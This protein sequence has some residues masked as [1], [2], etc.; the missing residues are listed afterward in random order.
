MVKNKK[1]LLANILVLINVFPIFFGYLFVNYYYL[2]IITLFLTF[3]IVLPQ[4][5]KI[6]FKE[7]LL[8][9]VVVL[10]SINSIFSIHMSN[11]LNF[12]F[13]FVLSVLNMLL[14]DNAQLDW[15]NK[16]I[17]VIWFS[18]LI[19]VIFVILHFVNPILIYN[20]TRRFFSSEVLAVTTQLAD[21]GSYA[22]ICPQTGTAGFLIS[23]FIIISFIKID[24]SNKKGLYVLFT[25]IGF[26][27]LLLTGKR[28]FLLFDIMMLVYYYF[29]AQKGN[30]SKKIFYIFLVVFLLLGGF[31]ILSR[32]GF[33][34]SIINKMLALQESN[35]ISNG[36]TGL[37]EDTFNIFKNNVFFGS[38]ISTVDYLLG[39]S[40]HNIY[41]QLLAELGIVF[42][43]FIIFMFFYFFFKVFK[44]EK[45][46]HS[47]YNLIS[48][49]IQLLFLL[50]GF[51]GNPFYG[52]MFLWIYFLGISLSNS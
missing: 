26:L 8:F 20:I 52:C 49:F 32:L 38:G 51:T 41:I 28:G 47:I 42:Y 5:F 33:T 40:S 4:G 48:L 18:S 2:Q 24:F 13:M 22:G 35:D 7:K 37:W 31:I 17:N 46:N 50:Y 16:C 27:S 45:K 43:P 3:F 21:L 23:L 9:I 29:F 39:N 44:Q 10:L 25:F 36:R 30:I 6:T 34:D 15:K 11:S 1:N 12:I 14:L 19:H